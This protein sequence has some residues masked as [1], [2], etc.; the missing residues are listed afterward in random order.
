MMFRG[1][2]KIFTLS[3]Q[4]AF[5]TLFK[6]VKKLVRESNHS[7]L[8]SQYLEDIKICILDEAKLRNS[9]VMSLHYEDLDKFKGVFLQMRQRLCADKQPI[10]PDET[11]EIHRLAKQFFVLR[12]V[13]KA[14]EISGVELPRPIDKLYMQG[15]PLFVEDFSVFLARCQQAKN[16][17]SDIRHGV[18]PKEE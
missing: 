8:P 15:K 3:D 12:A 18:D 2:K 17:S 13:L 5:K 11:E 4:K 1:G 9:F 16:V 7:K 6:I 10:T 14:M